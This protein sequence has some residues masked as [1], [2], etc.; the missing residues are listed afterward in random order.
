ML[1]LKAAPDATVVPRGAVSHKGASRPFQARRIFGRAT[2]NVS[3]GSNCDLRHP[4]A[5]RLECADEPTFR[6]E[7]QLCA[8]GQ[9]LNPC[10]S[11]VGFVPRGD[12]PTLVDVT[13]I[14]SVSK[15][16]GEARWV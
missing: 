15:D 8:G 6:P 2:P 11:N 16:H 5:L 14:A 7:R 4:L 13:V 10:P 12:L 1:V 3:N 9:S